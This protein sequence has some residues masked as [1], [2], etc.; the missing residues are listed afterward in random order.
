VLKTGTGALNID[1]SRVGTENMS[2]QWDREWN[3]NSGPMGK[4]YGQESRERGK[5]VPDGRWPANLMFSHVPPDEDGLGGCVRE[6][7]RRVRSGN[8]GSAPGG[9]NPTG[10][11]IYGK[12]DAS[13]DVGGG[14]AD[15]DGT[16]QVEAWRCVEGCPVRALD[17]QSGT[18]RSAALGSAGGAFGSDTTYAQDATT[19][20][21]RRT[22]RPAHG[23]SGGASRFFYTAKA[24]RK[25]RGV[26]N[27]HPT[28]KPLALMRYLC[29]MVTPPGGVVLDPFAGSGTTLLAAR[30]EGLRAI[31]IEREEE[32]AAIASGRLEDSP[33]TLETA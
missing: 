25:E 5:T 3:E 10:N 8:H 23:D 17:E 6:G 15:P 20:A 4:R 16:E 14:Y 7:T 18:S 30:S 9:F 12:G 13:L 27:T 32:Y 33:L 11:T 22:M 19:R 2:A 24:S 29:R 21:M 26:G 1:A 28:V 31:G